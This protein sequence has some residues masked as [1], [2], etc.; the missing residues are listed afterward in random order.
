MFDRSVCVI[1]SDKFMD[2]VAAFLVGGGP[3]AAADALLVVE[4]R[5]EVSV[6]GGVPHFVAELP[7]SHAPRAQRAARALAGFRA[8]TRAARQ[9]ST[10]SASAF[11][12][13]S[14]SVALSSGNGAQ[15]R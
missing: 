15:Q 2:H 7:R 5:A 10:E 3:D 14:G 4:E 12:P 9:A 1:S 8:G 6:A 13:A 11:K